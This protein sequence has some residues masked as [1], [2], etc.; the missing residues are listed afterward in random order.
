MLLLMA[1]ILNVIIII[2]LDWNFRFV[3]FIEILQM[4][5]NA[6]DFIIADWRRTDFTNLT[7]PDSIYF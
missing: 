7:K 1:M 3:I 5:Y 6:F 2:L 4:R